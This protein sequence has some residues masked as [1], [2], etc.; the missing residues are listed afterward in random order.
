MGTIDEANQTYQTYTFNYRGVTSTSLGNQQDKFLFDFISYP[1]KVTFPNGVVIETQSNVNNQLTN[2]SR[3]CPTC[4]ALNYKQVYY[5]SVGN[6]TTYKDFLNHYTQ[7]TYDTSNSLLLSEDKA[8]DFYHHQTTTY[9]WDT[10][11]RLPT[12]VAQTVETPVG[13]GLLTSNFVYDLAGNVTSWSKVA[14]ATGYSSTR[15]GSATYTSTGQVETETDAKGHTTHYYY[16]TQSNLVKVKNALNQETLLGGYDTMGYLGWSEDPNGL[17][18]ELTYDLRHNI[19]QI[20]KGCSSGAG[21]HWETYTTTY[22]PFQSVK[23][24]TAPNGTA[25]EYTY[26]T[27]HRLTQTDI[28]DSSGNLLGSNVLTLNNGGDIL[29]SVFKNASGVIIKQK[30]FEYDDLSRVKNFLD[31]QNK[32]FNTVTD[33]QGLVRSKTDPLSHSS[34]YQ[35]DALNQLTGITNP[36]STQETTDYGAGGEVIL[37]TDAKGVTTNY[38]Y[39]GFGNVVT[40]NSPDTGIS[41][42]VFDAKNNITSSTDARGKT[43]THSYDVLDRET[44]Q[45][46]TSSGE[47]IVKTYGS[48]SKGIGKLCSV[49]DR[50]GTTSFTY[51]LWG[52]TLSKTSVMDGHTFTIGY[53]YDNSGQLTDITYPSGKVV[54]QTWLNG[55]VSGQ[56]VGAIPILNN[57]TYDAWNNLKGWTWGSGRQ[58]VYGYDLDGRV[59]DIRYGT[60]VKV[61]GKDDAWRTTDVVQT[62]PNYSMVYNYDSRDRL[63]SSSVWGSY[64][65]DDNS[66]RLSYLGSLGPLSYGYSPWNNGLEF[67]NSGYISSEANGNILYKPGMQFSYDD[68]SRMRDVHIGG[69]V[70]DYGVNGLGERVYKHAGTDKVY[71]VYA[72]VGQ[73][74]GVYD[75]S[76]LTVE[77]FAYLGTRPV[78]SLRGTDVYFVETDETIT[79]V[80]VLDNINTT[81]WSWDAKEPFGLSQPTSMMVGSSLFKFYLRF[82]G[83]YADEETGLFQN[84]FRDYDPTTGRYMEGDPLGLGAG[85]NVYG[86]VNGSPLDTIDPQGLSGVL[87]IYATGK[88]NGLGASSGSA[89]TSGHAWISFRKDGGDLSTYGT[90][91]N[92]PDGNPN[93]LLKNVELRRGFLND[94]S[95]NK[96]KWIDDMHETRL[97]QVITNYGSRGNNGWGI[98]APCSTFARDAWGA[99]TGEYLNVYG[100]YSNPSTLA[101]SIRASKR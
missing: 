60:T 87:T 14:T 88:F 7:R 44:L 59:S 29:S 27:A 93:G 86:Y 24:I 54:H 95:I 12:T 36:D 21:C 91:G 63:M 58:V 77:E 48:C 47:T 38:T 98:T 49:T 19:T 72:G 76:G 3:P 42:Y 92:N 46:A 5:D 31:H 68:W 90:W 13:E 20:R 34:T 17:R 74:L 22:T 89:G 83:Q 84:G 66:N 96:S 94:P 71:Y 4:S 43:I 35:Y 99:G 10:A 57:V 56:S 18:T 25:I 6:P 39:D 82:P 53:T 97:N 55:N 51:D 2:L 100:P 85:M 79:P 45:S 30:D 40:L 26:D 70:I 73:L 37:K 15:T 75:V 78:A 28:L 52:R 9:S 11:L 80:R 69:S 16:D 41:N 61:I 64:T 65:Y 101:N 50:T 33:D 67:F 32:A 8:K 23:K 1:K 62:S 81:V